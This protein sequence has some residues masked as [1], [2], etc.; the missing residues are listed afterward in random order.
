M[1][2]K[3]SGRE[4][5]YVNW[6]GR[7][8]QAPAHRFNS[9][10]LRNKSLK[11]YL[12]AAGSKYS[13]CFTHTRPTAITHARPPTPHTQTHVGKYYCKN[14]Q[15]LQGTHTYSKVTSIGLKLY[16]LTNVLSL[17]LDIS[18]VVESIQGQL[19]MVTMQFWKAMSLQIQL[20]LYETILPEIPM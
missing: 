19:S 6:M 18:L 3:L 20:Q 1:Q 8:I 7:L 14:T 11:C 12:P 16:C 17:R 9:G 5:V 15:D 4:F 13:K 2:K 10:F